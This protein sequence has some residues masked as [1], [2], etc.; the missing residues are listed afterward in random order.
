VAPRPD[1][2]I[3]IVQPLLGESL[4]SQRSSEAGG[5]TRNHLKAADEHLE[6]EDI[7]S[8]VH[9]DLVPITV[10]DD[11]LATFWSQVYGNITLHPDLALATEDQIAWAVNHRSP[12]LLALVNEFVDGHKAGASFGNTLLQRYLKDTKWVTNDTS[13]YFAVQNGA[14]YESH[15]HAKTH[16]PTL[17]Q[18]VAARS[19]G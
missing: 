13:S 14:S 2:P 19:L 5:H 9:A 3:L 11:Q 16:F 4:A 17:I 1:V 18:R 12:N 7:L 6:D 10:M 8:M 15:A